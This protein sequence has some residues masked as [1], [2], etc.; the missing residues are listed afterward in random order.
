MILLLTFKL[1]IFY[2]R[3]YRKEREFEEGM[4]HLQKDIDMLETE[5]RDLRENL[6][7]T[8]KKGDHKP[9]ISTGND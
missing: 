6:K 1:M 7:H 3:F 9:I 4:N 2:F 5:K 8:N